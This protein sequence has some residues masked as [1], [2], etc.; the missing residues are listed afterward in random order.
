MLIYLV[1]VVEDLLVTAILAGVVLSYAREAW[2]R[3]GSRCVVAA[4]GL[5]LVASIVMAYMK[6]NTAL[7]STG[8]W[9]LLIF[10]VSLAAALVALVFQILKAATRKRALG[11]VV[12]VALSLIV[13]MR[14]FYKVPDVVNYPF[15]FGITT[16]NIISTDFAYRIVGWLVGIALAVL[17]CIAIS[18]AYLALDQKR[19]GAATAAIVGLVCFVQSV[20]LCQIFIARRI[21]RKGDGLYDVMFPLTTWFSNNTVL[22]TVVIAAIAIALAVVVIVLS[23]QDK[24]PY[25]NPA[26]H[27]KNRA[28]WRNRRRWAICAIVCLLLS[29]VT[30]TV[31]KDYNNQGPVIVESEDVEVSDGYMRIPFEQVDDG[32]LHRFTYETSAGVQVTPE[33]GQPYTTQGGVGVRVIVIKKPGANAYGVGLDACDICGTTGYYERD[34]QVVCSKCDVVMNINTIGFKGGCNP[35]VIDYEMKDGYILIPLDALAAYEKIPGSNW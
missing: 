14:V 26:E 25:S 3:M 33:T 23:L 27:R 17:T 21:I 16:D 28:R 24:E 12:L 19:L 31:V 13:F 7:I 30:V 1:S 20:S 2:S 10:S 5:G 6:Q 8:D 35:I 9:N 11:V 15:N 29:I 22:I 34:G 32:H 4:I 18:K